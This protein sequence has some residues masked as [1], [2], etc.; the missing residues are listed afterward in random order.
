MAEE[1][2]WFESGGHRVFGILH[3]PEE[4][5]GLVLL[6]HGFTGNHTGS[7]YA[8]VTLARELCDRGFTV[9]RFDYAGSGNSEGAFADQRLATCLRDVQNAVDYLDEVDVATTPI[10]LMG[11]S[12]G[13]SVAFLAADSLPVDAVVTWSTVADYSDLR[14]DAYEDILETQDEITFW[15]FRLPTEKLTELREYDFEKRAAEVEAP[16]LFAHGKQDETTPCSHSERLY[17]RATEPKELL[18]L[19]DADHVFA[20]P[21]DREALIRQTADWFE[22]HL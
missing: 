3:R 18:L 22:T 13:G 17:D 20:D 1:A 19:K 16:V 8:F 2:H 12:M 10:G 9:F 21:D 7:K 15:G 6:L 11:H 14:S 5:R 4:S